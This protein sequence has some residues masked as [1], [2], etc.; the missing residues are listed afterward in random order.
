MM[1][2]YR[3]GELARRTGESVKTLRFWS[4]EGLLPL[5]RGDN[6]YRYYPAGT[7][8]RVAAVRRFQG[9]GFSLAEI[10]EVLSVRERGLRPCREVRER[11]QRHLASTRRRLAEL[12]ALEEALQER[13][14]WADEH[15]DAA[16][17]DPDGVCVIVG[18]APGARAPSASSTSARLA[19]AKASGA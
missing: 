19:G 14:A 3:I 10:A 13:L 16:C 7:D 17:E 6:R 9:L 12:V 2:V 8:R 1:T 11:L 4:D 15:P 18:S 5:E